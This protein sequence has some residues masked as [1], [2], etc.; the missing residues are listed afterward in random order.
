M[1]SH[2]EVLLFASRLPVILTGSPESASFRLS[3]SLCIGMTSRLPL[4][5]SWHN[6]EQSRLDLGCVED[7]YLMFL[8]FGL[9][10]DLSWTW[11]L[12][13]RLLDIRHFRCKT[14][15]HSYKKE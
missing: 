6:A 9:L 5:S 13:N 15:E 4:E 1:T 14:H 12:W 3:L 10:W 7:L 8:C 11:Q 2:S